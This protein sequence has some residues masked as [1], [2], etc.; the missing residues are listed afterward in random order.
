MRVLVACERSGRVR[1]AFIRRGHNAVSCDLEPG[2][3]EFKEKHIQGDILPVLS[4]SF[5]LLIAFPPCT[6]ICNSGVQYLHTR[7]GRWEDMRKGAEFFKALWDCD[8]K[9]KCLENP[10]MHKYAKAIVQADQSQSIQPYDFG[11][12]A[13]KRTCLWL[14][15]LPEL[16]GT[17]YFPPRI[18]T[19]E[20]KQYKRWGNQTDSGQNRLGPSAD[21]AKIRA[22]TYQGIAD[23]M[24]EQWGCVNRIN[25]QN[26]FD[27]LEEF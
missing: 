11:E 12:D 9:L 18:V 27:F 25:T 3:G 19:V 16:K 22:T 6:F 26:E 23:A 7:E 14:G 4:M 5:D 15:G 20:G 17:E 2:E 10:I 24:A 21:R 1:D 13:S 8:I